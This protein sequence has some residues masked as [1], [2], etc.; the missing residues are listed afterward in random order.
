VQLPLTTCWLAEAV[1]VERSALPVTKA[2]RAVTV[3]NFRT[4]TV[5]RRVMETSS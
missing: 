5:L 4:S 1:P 3:K 2:A